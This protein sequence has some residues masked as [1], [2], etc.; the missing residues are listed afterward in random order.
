MAKTREIRRRI[1]SIEK[2]RQIT[3]TM[4]MIATSKLKRASDRVTAARPYARRLADVICRLL[5]PE[6]RERYPLL[7][8][9]A[10]M[11]RAAV[12]LLTSNRGQAGAFHVNLIREAKG[13]MARLRAEGVEPE[14]YVVGR[15]AI[16][17]FR[18]ARIEM[19]GA[20]TDIT[21]RPT[22]ADAASLVEP[23]VARF[24]AGEIDAIHV[25]Y[26]QFRSALSTPPAVMRVLPIEPAEPGKAV[27]ALQANSKSADVRLG[28]AP[29]ASAT[30]VL[31]GFTA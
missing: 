10:P 24:V 5:D 23:L 19:K 27:P 13:L 7:R 8:Q 18:F 22:A 30:T 17:H 14:L 2:T 25:V 3:R 1:R 29:I 12:L 15:K 9:A 31:V 26:A 21:D 11:R 16:A 28:V 6:L 4:E 20:R